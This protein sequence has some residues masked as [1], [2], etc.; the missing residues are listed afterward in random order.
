MRFKAGDHV[1]IRP[2]QLT[3]QKKELSGA[4]AIVLEDRVD[5]KCL[6]RLDDSLRYGGHSLVLH[7]YKLE[8]YTGLDQM[9][10][11]L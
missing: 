5:S 8:L 10:E 3:T 6:L 1:R 11:L 9:L 7:S 2:E 4:L